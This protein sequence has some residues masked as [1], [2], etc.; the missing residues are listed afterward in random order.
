[1]TA[2]RQTVTVPYTIDLLN[3]S[4]FDLENEIRNDVAEAFAYGEGNKFVLGTGAKQPEGFLV[5]A[6]VIAGQSTSATSG[7]VVF[8]D[9]LALTGTLKAGYNPIFGFNRQTLAYLRTLKDGAGAYVWQ[10]GNGGLPNLIAG[11]RY[12]IF[13][14]M[15]SITNSSLSIVYGDFLRGYLITDRTG[16]VVVR[17]EYAKKRQAIVEVT[18]HRWNTGQVVLDEAITVLKTKA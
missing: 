4:Q 2:Y 13:Q 14:D 12:A 9:I 15:P 10:P 3:D 7:T 1:L 11:E 8:D 17:D 6:A 5:N 18:Y 16:M